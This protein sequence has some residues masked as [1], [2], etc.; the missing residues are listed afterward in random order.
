MQDNRDKYRNTMREFL[1][2]CEV[3]KT[4]VQFKDIEKLNTMGYGQDSYTKYF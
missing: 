4:I 1:K 2:M 3:N